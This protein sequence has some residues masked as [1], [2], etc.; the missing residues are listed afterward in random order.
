[1]KKESLGKEDK[2]IKKVVDKLKGA[3]QHDHKQ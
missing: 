2:R 1:M 3:S